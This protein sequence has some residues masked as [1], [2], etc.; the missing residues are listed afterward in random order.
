LYVL[1][2]AEEGRVLFDNLTKTIAYTLAHT[3]PELLSVVISILF[4]M[5]V[6]L[7]SLM[8]LR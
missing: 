7:T 5:P 1:G 2:T 4:S 3:L 6:G 8:I